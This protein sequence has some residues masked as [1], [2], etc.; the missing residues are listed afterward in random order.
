MAKSQHDA[1]LLSKNNLSTI[2][3]KAICYTY[4]INILF[5]STIHFNN[6]LKYLTLYF[7]SIY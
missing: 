4:C 5:D 3:M 7:N 2:K 6:I 1:L